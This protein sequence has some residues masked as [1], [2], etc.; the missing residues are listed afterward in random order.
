MQ[1]KFVISS[2][3][4]GFESTYPIVI[5]S[6]LDNGVPPEDIY[7]IVGGYNKVNRY[8]GDD[9]VN[10][11]EVDQNSIDYTGLIAVA[12]LDLQADYWVLLHDTCY[13]GEDFYNTIKKYNYNNI[14]AVALS[15][16]LS[17]NIGAYSYQYLQQIKEEL[18]TYRNTDFSQESIQAWKQRGIDDEDKFLS[19]YRG[20][21][22]YCNI[23]RVSSGP[24]DI[25]GTGVPRMIE[26]FPTIDLYKVKANWHNK[27]TYELNV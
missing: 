7:F 27:S 8:I 25:Y 9:G 5:G 1:I 12:D 11:I 15:S 13:V 4:I 26:Y 6:L 3:K 23:P 24:V 16:D 2:R 14:P 17:M 10:F 18:L 21:Y 22:H 19:L 20:Q